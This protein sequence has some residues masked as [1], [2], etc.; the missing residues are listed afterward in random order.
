M[1]HSLNMMG[2]P[3]RKLHVLLLEDAVEDAQ[4]ILHTIESAGLAIEANHVES[5]AEYLEHLHS[6][7]PDIILSDY[8]VPGYNGL[9]AFEDKRDIGHHCPFILVTGTLSDEIAVQCLRAGIDDYVLKDRLSRLPDAVMQVLDRERA[10]KEKREA[11]EELIRSQRRLEAAEKLAK[12]GSWEW[13][14]TNDRIY[15]S[16]EMYNILE[17]N[18]AEFKPD[19]IAFLNLLN[20]EELKKIKAAFKRLSTGEEKSSETTIRIKTL[21]GQT[22]M[23]RS[24]YRTNGNSLNSEKMKVYGTLQDI[25]RQ[26]LAEKALRESTELLEERVK[27]RTKELTQANRMLE[28]KNLEMIDSINYA[29]L[30]QSALLSKKEECQ[31]LFPQSFVLWKP[32]DIVSG[33]FY[34]QYHTKRYDFIAV[35]DCTGH[36]VPGALMS[37]IGHQLLNEVV[38]QR[39]VVEPKRILEYLDE[40]VD[41]ALRT[42]V[43]EGVKDGMDLILCRI[44]HRDESVCYSGA[45]RPLF[46]VSKGVLTEFQGSKCPI[47]NFIYPGRQKDYVQHC[48]P[49]VKGD[50]IYLTSDGY[51]SQFGGPNGKKM[52]KARFKELLQNIGGL[53][54]PMQYTQLSEYLRY[55]QGKEDQVDDILVIGIRL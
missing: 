44:D 51:Y 32:R 1:A 35:V 26:F 15:L 20:D 9:Q 39:G 19:T 2:D 55:W 43:G 47:G 37:M 36:G 23:V 50:S 28:R 31:R 3:D 11:L 22:K 21:D 33:D 49:L 24:L 52:L 27:E 29:Q 10:N 17:T 45:L 7:T 42:Q 18:K 53:P 46:H 14:P 30:I 12:V 41:N 40:R 38:I 25:T 8:G 54:M 5:K 16:D 6:K 13:N 4:L 34:W 48:F